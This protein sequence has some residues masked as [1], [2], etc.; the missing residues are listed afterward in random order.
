MTGELDHVLSP[1]KR[2]AGDTSAEWSCSFSAVPAR[3]PASLTE[4]S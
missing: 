3:L 1:T 2:C 4:P